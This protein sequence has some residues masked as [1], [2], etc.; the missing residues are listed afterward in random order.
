MQLRNERNWCYAN[1]TI[2]GLF[3]TLLCLLPVQL[4]HWG[5]RSLALLDFLSRAASRTVAL[6]DESWFQEI[7]RSWGQPLGQNDGAE[8]SHAVLAWL[9][10]PAIDMRWE[11][12][13]EIGD[14][15][16]TLDQGHQHM[17]I[18]LE[19]SLSMDSCGT[20]TL[21]S[22]VRTWCQVDAMQAALCSA[23]LCMCLQIDRYVQDETGQIWRTGCQVEFDAAVRFPLFHTSGLQT[24]LVEYVVVAGACHVGEDLAGHCRAFLRL[25]PGVDACNQP[26]QWLITDDDRPSEKVWHLPPW[27]SRNLTVLW[28]LRADCLNLCS[29]L[30]SADDLCVAD[31]QEALLTLLNSQPDVKSASGATVTP[32]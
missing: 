21:L 16:Q 1:S 3:W 20:C 8:F 27:M 6:T 32:E 13:C 9:D 12:R 31:P 17:P 7:L 4:A 10:S 26:Y 30:G 2:L 5:T 28:L 18:K 25:Q 11:R 14:A 23:S 29:F 22:L 15:V 24:E 19:I